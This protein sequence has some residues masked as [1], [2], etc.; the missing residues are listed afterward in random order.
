MQVQYPVNRSVQNKTTDYALLTQN[1]QDASGSIEDIASD[2]SS[3]YAIAS[4]LLKGKPRCDANFSGTNLLIVE[5]DNS[6]LVKNELGQILDEDG[7]VW[8]KNNGKKQAKEY[9]PLFTIEDALAD[10]FT[11]T[12]AAIVYTSPSHTDEWNRFR[13]VFILPY[14]INDPEVARSATLHLMRRYGDSDPSCKDLCRAWYGNTNAI[15]PILQEVKLPD[16]FLEEVLDFNAK[17]LEEEETAKRKREAAKR[18]LDRASVEDCIDLKA[19]VRQALSQCPPR[20]PG[21]N[22]YSVSL[23]ILT[24]IKSIFGESEGKEIAEQW[25]PSEKG[26][27]IDQK[28]DRLRSD[29]QPGVIF[30]AAK[31]AGWKFPK[32]A[33]A[34]NRAINRI[35]LAESTEDPAEA[36]QILEHVDSEL[37][38]SSLPATQIKQSADLF[39]EFSKGFD[40]LNLYAKRLLVVKRIYPNPCRWQSY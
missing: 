19:L 32:H 1:Y 13:I 5:F 16:S 23:A 10:A 28:W 12:Y 25:S 37:T 3:G 36:I 14:L 31:E 29:F 7:E 17:R 33:E 2:I 27:M 11:S 9:A 8:I 38:S 30:K 26:W 39:D 34:L 4:G 22:T 24:A 15:F 40:D 35:A 20:E 21:T 6:K 18:L